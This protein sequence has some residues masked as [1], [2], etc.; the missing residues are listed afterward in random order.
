MSPVSPSCMETSLTSWSVVR[1][2][3][4][5][6]RVDM[7]GRCIGIR[8]MFDSKNR[9]KDYFLLCIAAVKS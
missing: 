9:K 7:G 2:A 4:F 8:D 1:I 3:L 6:L 5:T